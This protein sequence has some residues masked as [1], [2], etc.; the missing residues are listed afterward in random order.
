MLYDASTDETF[1]SREYDIQIVDR[2]G[3]GDSFTAG[4]IYSLITNRKGQDAVEFA[5]AASCLKHTIEGDFNGTTVA[6]AEALIKN[7]GNGREQR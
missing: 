7:G 3:G 6:D 2:V 5:A 4:I 1:F